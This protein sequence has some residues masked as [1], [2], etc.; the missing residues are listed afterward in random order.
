MGP[1]MEGS[2][3]L[4]LQK[5][6]REGYGIGSPLV[7]PPMASGTNFF[8]GFEQDA[9]SC[10]I[11]R[12]LSYTPLRSFGVCLR[13]CASDSKRHDSKHLPEF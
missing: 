2:R 11:N 7:A 1:A 6:R 10:C 3:R 12:L 9:V 13:S 8:L 5:R 4:A